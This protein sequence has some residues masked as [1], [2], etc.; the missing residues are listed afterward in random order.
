MKVRVKKR[1]K[2]SRPLEFSKIIAIVMLTIFVLTFFAAW[3]TY[4]IQ[5]KVST[6]LLGFISTPLMV[7]ITGY[8]TKSGVENYQKINKWDN[9][10]EEVTS[11]NSNY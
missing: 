2:G 8:F 3:F 7:I 4:I 6:E 9:E 11:D 10:Q 5:N 1:R